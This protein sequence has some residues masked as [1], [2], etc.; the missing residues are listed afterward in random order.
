[1]GSA[2]P[3]RPERQAYATPEN[4][5]NVDYDLPRRIHRRAGVGGV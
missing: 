5:L 3:Y 4:G 2:A 1:M